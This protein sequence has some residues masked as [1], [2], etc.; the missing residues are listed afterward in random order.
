MH[1][2]DLLKSAATILKQ[3]L[4]HPKV[5]V[6]LGLGISLAIALL[7]VLDMEWGSL[8]HQFEDF[9]IGY[10]LASLF[11]FSVATALRAYRWQVLFLGEKVPLHRLL[12]VQNAGIGINS[13]SPIRIVSEAAQ[14]FLLTIRY[15]VR[16]EMVAATLGIQRVLDFVIGAILLGIGLMLLP[17][18]KGF[19]LYVIGAG[20]LA[21]VSVIAVPTVIWFGSRPGLTHLQ[22]LASTSTS[23]RNLVK[24]R[25]KLSWSFLLTLGYWLL[26]GSSA[27]ILAYGMGIEISLL[28]ATL[29]V[30]GTLTFVALIPSLP[31]SVGTFEFAV[32]Y[33]LTT[34]GVGSGEALG[35]ALVI[36]AILFLPPI[37]IAVLVFGSWTLIGR[38]KSPANTR[39]TATEALA[40]QS[41][42]AD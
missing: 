40:A 42:P 16:S 38:S 36:H 35:F 33:F 9:P 14:F 34:I 29:L 21:A 4:W 39:I 13:I 15:R 37:L 28:V 24:A 20:V 26:L 30:I 22:L 25:V 2:L 17:G 41:P 1:H 3:T 18:L 23:L 10:A 19:A 27:W 8:S 31:A 11:I 5:R 12:L 7:V 32:Y 6:I